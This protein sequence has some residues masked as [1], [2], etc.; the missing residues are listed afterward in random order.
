MPALVGSRE[1]YTMRAGISTD[2]KRNTIMSACPYE[3]WDWETGNIVYAYATLD[4]ALADVRAA[5][6]ENGPETIA[7]WFLQYDDRSTGENI[8]DGEDLI[9]LA[10]NAA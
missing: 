9:R 3:I 5:A 2:I 10:M 4:E 7:T 8:A 6:N 1:R